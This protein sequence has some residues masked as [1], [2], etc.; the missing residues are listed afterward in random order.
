MKEKW[1]PPENDGGGRGE[2]SEKKHTPELTF[3]LLKNTTISSTFK[4]ILQWNKTDQI[5]NPISL[6]HTINWR[7]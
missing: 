7:G 1:R 2:A 5:T 3:T 6:Y 4:N